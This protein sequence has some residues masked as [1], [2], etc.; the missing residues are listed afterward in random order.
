M[1]I[2]THVLYVYIYTSVYTHKR[3]ENTYFK[4]INFL[5]MI[6]ILFLVFNF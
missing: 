6:N 5:K 1:I 3:Q 2:D 4:E